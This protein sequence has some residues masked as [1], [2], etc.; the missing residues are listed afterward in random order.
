ML[1]IILSVAGVLFIGLGLLW[2]TVQGKFGGDESK[3]IESQAKSMAD[4]TLAG[5]TMVKETMVKEADAVM[6]SASGESVLAEVS[7]SAAAD[8]DTASG[9]IPVAGLAESAATV[10]AEK[11]E[12]VAAAVAPAREM[13]KVGETITLASRAAAIS[14]VAVADS[15]PN[16]GAVPVAPAQKAG[17]LIAMAEQ[18]KSS[19]RNEQVGVAKAIL[20]SSTQPVDE[21]P[22]ATD[23]KAAELEQAKEATTIGSVDNSEV[24]SVIKDRVNLRDGPSIDHPIVLTLEQGQELME[25]KRDGKWVHVGAFGTSGKIG[26]V[27]ERLVGPVAK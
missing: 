20:A 23:E 8:E 25:F 1:K 13:P 11:D 21:A 24:L 16:D 5:E 9:R 22:A 14:S 2:P 18:A 15:A 3:Q 4:T 7:A 26:W 12:P 10:D 19:S 17:D 6:P 27:H